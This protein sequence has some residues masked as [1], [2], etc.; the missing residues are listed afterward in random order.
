L[1]IA[2][3]PEETPITRRIS[4]SKGATRVQYG[5]LPY[6]LTKTRSVELLLVTSRETKRW[7]IPKGW[8]IDGLKPF[9]SAAQE[10]YEEAGIRGTVG[11]RPLGTYAY[12]KRDRAGGRYISCEV[13]VFPLLVKDQRGRWPEQ[14]QRRTKWVSR[15]KAITLIADRKLRALVSEFRYPRA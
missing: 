14:H 3:H 10:A 7:I 9:K 11:K 4:R 1:P 13:T 12:R 6:R 8:P 5:A 15:R 2:E